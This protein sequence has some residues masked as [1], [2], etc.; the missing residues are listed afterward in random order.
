MT[1]VDIAPVAESA[2]AM[3][4][5][6]AEERALIEQKA[7]S[8][9]AA[10]NWFAR[11]KLFLAYIEELDETSEL[12][13]ELAEQPEFMALME[14][15]VR[16]IEGSQ[17]PPTEGRPQ[18]ANLRPDALG[19]AADSEETW[20]DDLLP[21]DP[22]GIVAPIHIGAILEQLGEQRIECLEQAAIYVLST[23]EEHQEAAW[24]WLHAEPKRMGLFRKFMSRDSRYHDALTRIVTADEQFALYDED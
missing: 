8:I 11:R 24:S 12:A 1:A 14:E 20:E 2:F 15:A 19:P 5:D 21:S 18:S 7:K 10:G 17:P 6:D 4:V 9:A 16:Q 3:M 22:F 23:H 13:A